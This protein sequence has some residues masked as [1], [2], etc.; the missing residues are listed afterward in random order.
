M[1]PVWIQA[2]SCLLCCLFIG[3]G[4]LVLCDNTVL[5]LAVICK[6][7]RMRKGSVLIERPGSPQPR[8]VLR[9]STLENVFIFK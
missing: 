9:L 1:N 4:S 2:L 3:L 8:Y 5:T 6:Q 7:L